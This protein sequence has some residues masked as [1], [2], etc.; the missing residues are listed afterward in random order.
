LKRR[1]KYLR[2][3]SDINQTAVILLNWGVKMKVITRWVNFTMAIMF[4]FS[5]ST[6][7]DE[8][9]Y[10]NILIGDRA[11]GMGGAYTAISDDASGLFYNPAG[12]VFVTDR[13]FSASVN[14]YA[15]QTKTYDNVIAGKPFVRRSSALLANYFG[16][17]RPVGDFKFGFSYAVPDSVG[18]DLDLTVNNVAATTPFD[19]TINLSNRDNTYNYGP[20]FAASINNDL[21]VGIT[22]YIHQREVLLIQNQFIARQDDTNQWTNSYFKLSET[23]LRPIIGLTWS[24]VEKLSLGATVSTTILFKSSASLQSTCVDTL[25]PT[26]CNATVPTAPVP[27]QIPTLT[28]FDAKRKYPVRAAIGAAYFASSNLLLSTDLT[29]HTAVDDPVFNNK[30]ATLDVAVGSE[31]YLS[32][33]WAMR[34]GLFSNVANTPPIQAGVTNIE[35]RI[36]LYGGSLS[37]TRFTGDSS[38]TLGGSVS[39]GAGQ[40]QITTK[41]EVQTARTFGWTMF[42]SSS[43]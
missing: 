5:I 3:Q 28:S 39:Y 20:S 17:V 26:N 9:H 27:F 29:Y 23:G 40:A 11:S 24:P 10:N 13:N 14:A 19:F 34:A 43:Y 15:A 21:S 36:N 22:L 41:D 2:R 38:V 7:A 32:K 30:V 35:E 25:T 37:F 18:E 8:F 16:I 31:Y 42:L 6:Y 1:V 12:I 4:G 33:Q